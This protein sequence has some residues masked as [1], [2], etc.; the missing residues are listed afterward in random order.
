MKNIHIKHIITKH[1]LF[2][3]TFTYI[4]FVAG[5]SNSSQMAEPDISIEAAEDDTQI[6]DESQF[7]SNSDVV[8]GV[9]QEIYGEVA[10]LDSVNDG[11]N[12]EI[13]RAIV[14][15]LG[16][17]GYVVIDSDNQI[18]MANKE[19]VLQFCESVDKQEE[20][21]L[22]ILVIG[23]AERFT[24]YELDTTNGMVDVLKETYQYN[25]NR[26]ENAAAVN[27]IADSWQYTEE[28][29][30]IFTGSSYSEESYVL[31][32][33]DV[34][35]AVALRVEP[36]DGQCREYN[37]CYIFLV[38]Y[39]RNNMFL[40]DWSEEDYGEL[41]FY[42]VFDRF[43]QTVYQKPV[44][45]VA[46]QNINIGAVYQIPEEEF[47]SV[48]TAHF[49]I[50]AETLHSK[51][52]YLP[53]QKAYDYRP[54]GFHEVEYTNIPYPEVVGYTMNDDGTITLTVNAVYPSE[55][56]SK[57]F[58]HEVVIRPLEDGAF[59]YVSNTVLHSKDDYGTGWHTDRLTEEEWGEIYGQ[60][61][62]PLANSQFI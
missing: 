16:E 14:Q 42:D 43:Y 61:P 57:A 19:Q 62:Q 21:R 13:I 45:Y 9:Y 32:M 46:D 2:I 20:A 30:L 26:F 28:G 37:N 10:G 58:S 36:L 59:Q 44:P 7:D 47:E 55:A 12:Q 24:K 41:D 53:E 8:A 50:D 4:L 15:K 5:C 11:Q 31:T 40:C 6:D 18:D 34:T 3:L 27:Y 49:A 51:T 25:N 23:T 22:E 17:K 52:R 29:Y 1:M 38:G 39:G 56:T 33:S 54:R 60:Q 48:V 35:E